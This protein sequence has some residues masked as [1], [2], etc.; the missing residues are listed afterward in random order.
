MTLTSL[1]VRPQD[2]ALLLC[3]A[4]L[5]CCVAPPPRPVDL[6]QVV[7][8]RVRRA[9]TAALTQAG[10][11]DLEEARALLPVLDPELQLA[12]ARE[13][14]ALAGR[15]HAGL[16]P[17]PTLNVD[18]ANALSGGALDEL[19][20]LVQVPLAIAGKQRALADQL[21]AQARLAVARAERQVFERSRSLEVDW[22]AWSLA[23]AASRSNADLAEALGG[24]LERIDFLVDSGNLGA[25]ESGLLR[26]ARIDA[27]RR[28]VAAAER[29]RDLE[30]RIL[31]ALGLRAGGPVALE[32]LELRALEG[33]PEG[34]I[35]LE[36]PELVAA[37]AVLELSEAAVQVAHRARFVEP[38]LG[39]GGGRE[40]GGRRLLF[41]LQVPLPIW[42]RGLGALAQAVARR[43]VAARAYELAFER[44]LEREERARRALRSASRRRAPLEQ[45]LL[46]LA[47]N[48]EAILTELLELGDLRPFLLVEAMERRQAAEL[49]RLGLVGEE[50]VARMELEALMA[51]HSEQQTGEPR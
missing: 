3:L 28:A 33:E 11:L 35:S 41:G 9:D 24:P 15:E 17:D 20:V 43:E 19:D 12:F 31:H 44:A 1:N 29:A 49:E 30:L 47:I 36:L 38:S 39:F 7:D 40:A 50:Q 22:V 37:A 27:E 16:W 10:G 5:P 26:L 42:N 8:R 4:A 23:L 45:G 14:P 25:V 21:D 2:L 6:D 18:L 46:P 51:P 32:P 13:L 48:Q 34:E